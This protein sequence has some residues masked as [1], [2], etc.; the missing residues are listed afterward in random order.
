MIGL[1]K[2]TA[3]RGMVTDITPDFLHQ[4]GVSAVLLDVDNTIAAYTSHAPIPGAVDWAR[5]LVEEGFRVVIVSNNYRKRVG[6]FAAKFG[7]DFVSFAMK[8]LPSGYLKACRKLNMR[9]RDCVVVGDQVFTDVVGAN[10]C[11]MRSI[12]LTPLE[13]EEGFTF[14]VRR[15]FEK[16]LREK[17]IRRKDVLQ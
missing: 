14:R 1:L 5:S 3:L 10:L 2:P 16:G 12:L 11:G 9:R 15:H 13:E 8:P 17:Y 7:L 4:L 6:P